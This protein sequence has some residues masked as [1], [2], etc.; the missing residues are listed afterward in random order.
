MMR[1]GK[2]RHIALCMLILSDLKVLRFFAHRE[3]NAFTLTKHLDRMPYGYKSS[4]QNYITMVRDGIF[5]L[6][7]YI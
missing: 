4:I 3:A 5:K 7:R 2:F 1:D 6:S